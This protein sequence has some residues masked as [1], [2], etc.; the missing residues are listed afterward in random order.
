MKYSVRVTGDLDGRRY[1][2]EAESPGEAALLHVMENDRLKEG[3]VIVESPG[4]AETYVLRLQEEPRKVPVSRN[5]VVRLLR[6]IWNAIVW[7]L[8]YALRYGGK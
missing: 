7:L 6:G 8:Y 2:V 4:S 3:C 1:E 5:P